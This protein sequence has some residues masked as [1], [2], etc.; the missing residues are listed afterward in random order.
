MRLLVLDGSPRGP[1]SNTG[2][3]LRPFLAAFAAAG[4]EPAET[5]HLV[6]PA[7]L[8]E[9]VRAFPGAEAVL[10]GF[11]LYCDALPAPAV[12]FVQRLAP[13]VGRP[14][15]PALLFLVQCGFPEALHLRP[16][17]RWLERL[18][19]RLGAPHLGTMLR[20]G[21]EGMRDRPPFLERA[22]MRRLERLG[23][24]LAS[25]GRLDAATLAALA[26][27]ERLA[28]GLLGPLRV[29]L[30]RRGGEWGWDRQLAANGVL[31]LR[32]ARP[33]AARG[34]REEVVPRP[35]P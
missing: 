25:E 2:L 29:A 5:L 21:A 9:A 4:G 26:G 22:T 28:A 8:D 19:R 34:A 23:R 27:R 11:P 31:A 20:P 32:D 13:F 30:G 6:R 3:L 14:R 1:R 24:A 10:L 18:A 12:A 7:H 16:V 33:Y 15:N 17:E 35:G